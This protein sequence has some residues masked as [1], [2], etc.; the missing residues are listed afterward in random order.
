MLAHLLGIEQPEEIITSPFKGALFE[1]HAVV[2][3]MKHY[4]NNGLHRKYYFW[5]DSNG[6]EID[7]IIERGLKIQCV[8]M[9]AS[10]TV[11][12]NFLKSLHYLDGQDSSLQIEHYLMNTLNESQKRTNET[13]LSWKDADKIT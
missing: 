7:L 3:I 11:K 13:I 12:S 6:N 9:K 10:Q 4:K 8:E 1:N 2:D 5:R